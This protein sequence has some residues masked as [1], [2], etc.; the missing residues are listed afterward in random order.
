VVP[1]GFGINSTRASWN[2]EFSINVN[3]TGLVAGPAL[4]RF[5]Y[6]LLID[7]DPSA[8]DNFTSFDPTTVIGDNTPVGSTN[9]VQNSENALFPVV[10][11]P[12]YN[13]NNPGLYDIELVVTDKLTGEVTSDEITIDV[14]P[15]VSSTLP[16][17]GAAV[18]GLAFMGRKVKATA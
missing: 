5:T 17:L 2:Y 11:V 4:G 1:E 13:P 9:L 8:A 7:S 12:G 15:E 18:L 10:G 16:L 3:A 14:V 6:Q